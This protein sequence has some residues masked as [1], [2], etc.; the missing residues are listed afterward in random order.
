MCNLGPAYLMLSMA[1]SLTCFVSAPLRCNATK[2]ES[3]DSMGER[4]GW[5][6]R[7]K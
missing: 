1:H 6:R 4:M 3:A 5:N 7:L 2:D